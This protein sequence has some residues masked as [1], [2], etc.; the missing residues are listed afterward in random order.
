M[1]VKKVINQICINHPVQMGCI[2]GWKIEILGQFTINQTE[3][4]PATL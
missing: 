2:I 1:D 4:F 3:S